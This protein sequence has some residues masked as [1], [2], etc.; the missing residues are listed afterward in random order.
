M[1]EPARP[2]PRFLFWLDLETTGMLPRESEIL[3]LA[4]VLTGFDYPYERVDA[5][6][7]LISGPGRVDL[8]QNR[9]DEWIQRTHEASGLR[10]ALED[11]PVYALPSVESI[12][13]A[14]ADK[15]GWSS[16]KDERTVIAGSSVGTFDLQFVRAQMPRL[17]ARLSHRAFD[18]SAVTLAA[19]SLGMPYPR[20]EHVAHRAAADIE[21]ALMLMRRAVAWLGSSDRKLGT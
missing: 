7:F 14:L 3:E 15:T 18:V 13:V 5:G 1:T 8:L 16:D 11:G 12:L 4:Y 2:K 19:R 9:C 6:S 20:T 10:A 21:G 17:A